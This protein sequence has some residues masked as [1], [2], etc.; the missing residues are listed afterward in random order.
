MQDW[1]QSVVAGICPDSNHNLQHQHQVGGGLLCSLPC[2]GIGPPQ[3]RSYST[4][5]WSSVRVDTSE[6]PLRMRSGQSQPLYSYFVTMW[7]EVGVDVCAR[8]GGLSL[9]YEMLVCC[10]GLHPAL[11]PW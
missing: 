6:L 8:A 4:L 2:H 5:A 1:Q 3:P 11:H 10:C 7:V 9:H